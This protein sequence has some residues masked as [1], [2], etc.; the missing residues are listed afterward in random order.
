MVDTCPECRL[1]VA[2][3]VQLFGALPDVGCQLQP[4]A[5]DA[6]QVQ[7]LASENSKTSLEEIHKGSK[8][9]KTVWQREREEMKQQVNRLQ[10]KY[11]GHTGG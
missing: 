4:A 6:E 10:D 5:P 9:D 11:K 1:P 2:S 7:R 8:K 3:R